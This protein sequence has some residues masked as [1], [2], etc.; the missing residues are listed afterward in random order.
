MPPAKSITAQLT[1]ITRAA[2]KV[3]AK[4]L[5]GTFVGKG[6]TMGFILDQAL[7]PSAQLDLA[8]RIASAVE[9]SGKEAGLGALRPKPV[10]VFRPGRIIAGFLSPELTINVR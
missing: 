2:V 1:S 3:A 9:V 4:D 8:T 6:P 5:K 7:A 10:V